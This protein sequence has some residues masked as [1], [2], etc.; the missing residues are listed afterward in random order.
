MLGFRIGWLGVAAAVA[1]LGRAESARACTTLG[2]EPP[3]R[4]QG[5]EYVP[6]N[7]VYFEVTAE[8]PGFMA[9]RTGSGEPIPAS[10]RT[11]GGGRVFGPDAP[12]DPGTT[13]VLEY[14]LNCYP[15]LEN[16]APSRGEFVFET[17]EHAP[18]TVQAGSMYVGEYG[19]ELPAG[20]SQELAFVR[21]QPW[22]PSVD[23]F[24]EHLV[25]YS[26]RVDGEPWSAFA[27]V[28]SHWQVDIESQCGV[29]DD[30]Y[31]YPRDSCGGLS[32]VPVGRHTLELTPHVAGYDGELAP[33]TLD[34]ETRCPDELFPSESCSLPSRRVSSNAAAA[35]LV[36]FGVAAWLRRAVSRRR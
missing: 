18:L 28:G 12:I 22:V 35:A 31:P 11:V 24:A 25:T 5:M 23:A 8:T 6:G 13:V 32:F 26:L 34:I 1:V 7:L 29:E 4:L 3:V 33:I 16:D 9:L 27:F 19:V 14:A 15:G 21:V 20:T 30:D 36:L 2:C 10:T 17:Y